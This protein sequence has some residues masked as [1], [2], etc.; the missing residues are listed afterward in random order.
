MT[1]SIACKINVRNR[2][3]AA[4]CCFRH[5]GL[6]PGSIAALKSWIPDQVRD[7][8][9][10]Y[11]GFRLFAVVMW[12]PAKAGA[13]EASAAL[14]VWIPAFAGNHQGRNR[15]FADIAASP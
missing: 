9:V 15:S 11:G 4:I 3:L 8:D 6:D 10:N 2:S 13:H 14:V 5:P 7:D 1:G 12:T